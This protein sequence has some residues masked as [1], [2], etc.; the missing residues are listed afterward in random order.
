MVVNVS[1]AANGV[2][3]VPTLSDPARVS[4]N[5]HGVIGTNDDATPPPAAEADIKLPDTTTPTTA[6]NPD[7]HRPR[8]RTDCTG[9][10]DMRHPFASRL[11]LMPSL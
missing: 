1:A 2:E 8:P 9:C 7:A 6:A 5:R 10:T 11:R 3:R 4:T